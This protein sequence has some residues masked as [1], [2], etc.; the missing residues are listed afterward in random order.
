MNNVGDI[1]QRFQSRYD[2]G[3]FVKDK[4][5]CNMVEIVGESFIANEPVI[6][7]IPNQDYIDRELMWYNSMSR[8]VKD[9]PGKTPDIWSKV[10][11]KNGVI[12]SNYGWCIWSTENKNQYTQVLRKLGRDPDT[13]QAVMIYNRPSMHADAVH[14]GRSDFMCTNAV[15]YMIRDD[16]LTAIVQMRSNDV[17]FGYNND[18]A[19]QDHVAELLQLELGLRKRKIVW[20]VGS[21]HIYSR[22]FWMI[23]CYIRFGRN[24]PK[25]D[26]ITQRDTTTGGTTL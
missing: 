23:D 6:F 21:L 24:L 18:F 1:R 15:Q 7:G 8:D 11:D 19:W 14:Q 13:R 26:Y 16:T 3:H 2:A 10:S 5:G 9:I 20:Q 12:N 4:S 22:H 25:E 17:V